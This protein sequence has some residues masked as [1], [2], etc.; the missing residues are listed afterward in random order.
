MRWK[1]LHW[2]ATQDLFGCSKHSWA[3]QVANFP[4]TGEKQENHR[5]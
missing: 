1:Y 3:K 4:S 2:V 5:G